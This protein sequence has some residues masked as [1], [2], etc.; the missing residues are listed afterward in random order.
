[1]K[2]LIQIR[3]LSKHYGRR[4][5]LDRISLDVPQG[6]CVGILGENGCGKSTM[7]SILAGTLRRDEGEFFCGG[8]DL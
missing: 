5:I 8:E 4:T 3:S 6:S 2:R 7:L 1:M